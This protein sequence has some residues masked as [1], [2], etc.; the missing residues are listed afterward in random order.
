MANDTLID[1]YFQSADWTKSKRRRLDTDIAAHRDH[2]RQHDLDACWQPSRDYSSQY[3][4]ELKPGPQRIAFTA[5]IVNIYEVGS[6]YSSASGSDHGRKR[7]PKSRPAGSGSS[8]NARGHL[9][10]LAKD[11]SGLIQVKHY[12]ILYLLFS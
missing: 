3:L 6:N 4:G 7:G 9:K 8:A 2:D 10:I 1:D 12:F 11:D 5:R